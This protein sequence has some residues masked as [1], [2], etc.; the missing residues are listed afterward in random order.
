MK[1]IP[2]VVLLTFLFLVALLVAPVSSAEQASEGFEIHFLDVGQADCSIVICDGKVLMIDGGNAADSDLVFSYLRNT[3]NVSH[4]DYMVSTHPHED[5]VGGLSGAL[6][7]CTVGEVF[8]PMLEYNSDPFRDFLKYAGRQGKLPQV[9]KAGDSYPLGSAS[10]QFLTPLRTTYPNENDHSLVVRV[11][12]GNTA[13]LF[14]ADAEL[15]VEADMI[16]ANHDGRI[17]VSADLIRA[18]HHG[19][20]YST[21]FTFLRVVK[22]STIVI[23]VGKDNKYGHPSPYTLERLHYAKAIVY[24]TDLHGHIICY[25]DGETITFSI[26]KK[27]QEGS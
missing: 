11:V 9:P 3:L 7:A 4:I 23:S 21:S 10:L 14:M 1:R 22:P 13:F 5:H 12:Y 15:S 18:G 8:S 16:V 17:D 24:R 2:H 6:N 27:A 20:E 19:G 25:S 26:E